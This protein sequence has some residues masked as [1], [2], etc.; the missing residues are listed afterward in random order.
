M[1]KNLVAEGKIISLT[2]PYDVNSGAGMLV[3]NIFAVAL[4]TAV[5]GAAV[6]AQRIGIFDLNKQS[7]AGIT[8]TQGDRVFWDNTNKRCTSD[9]NGNRLIGLCTSAA[10][11]N[12][13]TVRVLVGHLP[14]PDAADAALSATSN[15]NFPS[16]AAA[17]SQD[18]TIAVAG[19]AVG[20]AVMLGLASAPT[21]GIVFQSFVS[22]A[23]TVT[24]RATNI[25]AAPV[26]PAAQD[27]RVT[28]VKK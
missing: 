28:V 3:G 6:D 8:F 15:L 26:D 7:G 20:D 23:D 25:T 1:A 24:V 13:A 22:A 9:A 16:V 11:N 4:M 17:N 12:D 10:A 21:A 5:S 18:L 27:I 2:A 14:P 19:A